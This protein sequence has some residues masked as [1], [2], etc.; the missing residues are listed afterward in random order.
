MRWLCQCFAHKHSNSAVVPSA[1]GIC[2]SH[3]MC[4]LWVHAKGWWPAVVCTARHA[5]AFTVRWVLVRH[6]CLAPCALS[7]IKSMLGAF[8][9]VQHA[10]WRGSQLR[11]HLVACMMIDDRHEKLHATANSLTAHGAVTHAPP[12]ARNCLAL[13]CAVT[14]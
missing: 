2:I 9:L 3:Q 10:A 6:L 14:R 11:G 7:H 1:P 8:A 4:W 13:F 12:L 5:T